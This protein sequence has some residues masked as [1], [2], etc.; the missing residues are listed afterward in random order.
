MTSAGVSRGV[1]VVRHSQEPGRSLQV[2]WDSTGDGGHH[3]GGTTRSAYQKTVAHRHEI[4]SVLGYAALGLAERARRPPAARGGPAPAPATASAVPTRA[5]TRSR[6]PG[7][8]QATTDPTQ[9]TRWWQAEPEANVILPTGPRVR[10]LRRT[11]RRRPVR[12]HPDRRRR[13]RTQA[14]SPQ[15]ATGSCSMWPP[16]ATPRTRTS[17]G[18]A[19][20]DC[21]PG[22]HRRHARACAGTAATATSWRRPPR[23]PPA[24]PSP[25]CARPTAARCQTRCAFSTGSP[26]RPAP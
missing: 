18:P 24:S 16:A 9:L 7:T 22:H 17:G 4:D 11:A 5:R 26:T 3:G 6:P 23:C 20:L 8:M 21:D 12:P 19:S 1:C 13:S 25:G 15:T 10:R 2:H 14:R